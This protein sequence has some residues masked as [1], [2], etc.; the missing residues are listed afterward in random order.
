MD[1][2]RTSPESGSGPNDS[3]LSAGEILNNGQNGRVV[4]NVSLFDSTDSAKQFIASSMT[5]G[6]QNMAVPTRGQSVGVRAMLGASQDA[7][8]SHVIS[9]RRGR[10]GV[11]VRVTRP[12]KWRRSPVIA[13][14]LAAEAATQLTAFEK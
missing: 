14:A 4:G 1:F 8:V 13:P 11:Q 5:R 10:W 3:I 7:P 2:L 6:T 9:I 12:P